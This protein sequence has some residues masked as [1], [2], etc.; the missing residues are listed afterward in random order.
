MNRKVSIKHVVQVFTD[1]LDNCLV[2]LKDYLKK[3]IENRKN[4]H[5]TFILREDDSVYQTI[6]RERQKQLQIALKRLV[7]RS[8]LSCFL[9]KFYFI[10]VLVLNTI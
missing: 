8:I 9:T 3:M 5:P 10:E 4:L 7:K 2:R 6:I 1:D